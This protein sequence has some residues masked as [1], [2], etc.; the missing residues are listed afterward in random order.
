MLIDFRAKLSIIVA[1]FAL[2]SLTALAQ[3]MLPLSLKETIRL[4]LENN[5]NVLTADQR[6]KEAEG[7]EQEALS[8]L[9]PNFYGVVSQ[10][11][12]TSN[13][14]ALGFPA[15][16]F[17]IPPLI[18]PYNTFD[19]RLYLAMTLF[20]LSS[21]S[22]HQASKADVQVAV[23]QTQLAREQVASAATVAYLNVAS[24]RQAV[25]SAEANVLLAQSLAKLSRDQHDAGIATGIDVARADTRLA[26][27]QVVV[28][29]ANRLPNK[30]ICN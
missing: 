6:E 27:Q 14:A 7:R 19:A 23:L 16:A 12:N 2:F 18:G 29:Q 10:S 11:N 28:A 13:L 15:K 3:T 26:Q 20:N 8:R 4:A 9:L 30:R 17:P 24:T 5:L 1:C 25:Q 21:L 22:N